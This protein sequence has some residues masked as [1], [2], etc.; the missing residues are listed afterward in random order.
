MLQ[1]SRFISAFIDFPSVS[2][3][4]DDYDYHDQRQELLE[5]KR[6]LTPVDHSDVEAFMAPLSP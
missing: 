6:G 2:S 4:W 3:A 5:R 1:A